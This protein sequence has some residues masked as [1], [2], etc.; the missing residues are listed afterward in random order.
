MEKIKLN[1]IGISNSQTQT[2]AYALIL[3]EEEG[4][5]RLPIIIGGF[6]AQSIAIEMENMH[7]N[8]PLTHDLF[9]NFAQAFNIT[10][11]EVIINKFEEGVFYAQLICHSD[12]GPQIIDSR[13][14]DAIALAVRFK[15][16]VYTYEEVMSA[17]GILIEEED[18]QENESKDQN[19]LED[20]DET[21]EFQRFTVDELKQLLNEAV[22][23]EEFERASHLRDE[24][25]R[26][27]EQQQ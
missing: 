27:E 21:T 23:K 1:I 10:L 4:Q 3:G 15:C 25:R 6:E 16:P 13:T 20:V 7:P 11:T 12:E 2:G 5:R 14:S 19:N 8:R 22:E 17:A 9:R 18:K 26:R 24:I